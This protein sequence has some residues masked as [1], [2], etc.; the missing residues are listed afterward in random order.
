MSSTVNA[1]PTKEFFISMLTRDIDV[2]AAIQELIDNSIDGAKRMCPTGDYSGLYIKITFNEKE[3]II[4]DNCGGIP[5]NIATDYAFRFGRSSN[6]EKEKDQYYT[7]VFGI[8]MKRSLFRLG[9]YF[10]INSQTIDEKFSLK[11]DVNAWMEDD[12]Q[13][14]Q[15]KLENEERNMH[16]KETGTKI[17]VNRLH[18]GISKQFALSSFENALISY[19]QRYR[20]LAIEKGL[21]ISVN[22]RRIVF[23]SEKIISTPNIH[24]YTTSSTIDEVSI[25]IIAGIAPKGTPENAGWYV[26][27]NGRLIVFAD[28]TSLTGWGED[29][30]RSYHP[31]LAFFRGFVF[32]ESKDP[33][34]LPWNTTKTNV[35]T[36]S[37]FYIFAK[38]KMREAAQQI[39][40]TCNKI[41]D[42][43]ENCST[44]NDDAKIFSAMNLVSLE[45]SEIDKL[46]KKA[47]NFSLVVPEISHK[48]PHSNI[49]FAKPTREIDLLKKQMGVT[50]NKEVGEKA[51]EYYYRKECNSDE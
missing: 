32:F 20:T 48:E 21:E 23:V 3:F 27:C 38:A 4:E 19:I 42:D 47:N 24:P 29:G 22:D 33:E 45:T 46:T 28:K 31:S 51:F 10:E 50:T 2:R 43:D 39:I 49:T 16:N 40:K 30:V 17:T 1:N 13:N 15:F 5:I 36:S 14:W 44:S 35:D 37:L 9:D 34:K 8:G 25:K 11:V 12:D 26:Y 18:D 6:R 41:I 7:G